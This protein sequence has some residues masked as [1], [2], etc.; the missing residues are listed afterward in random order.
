MLLVSTA[1][2]KDEPTP[3]VG[4][5]WLVDGQEQKSESVFADG[6]NNELQIDVYQKSS[7][8]AGNGSAVVLTLRVPKRTGTYSLTSSS[9]QASAGY[10]DY[11]PDG[12]GKGLYLATSG[13][14]TL[15]TLTATSA[16]GTF[17]FTGTASGNP[18]F[19]KTITNG[20]FQ[21][22]LP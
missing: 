8:S 11:A 20:K 5:S 2:S 13:S 21:V 3:A 17:T 7:S 6:S 4:S 16:T 18:Q 12:Q 22:S 9:T 14:I 15:S 1:C 19:T 10:A